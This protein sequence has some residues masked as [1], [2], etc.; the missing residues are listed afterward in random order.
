MD[1][2]GQLDA[3][4]AEARAALTAKQQARERALALSRETIRYSANAIRAI[5]RHDVE[6]ARALVETAGEKAAGARAAL[7]EH[8]DILY[9]GFV[10]DA[11]KEF[12]EARITIALVGGEPLPTPAALDVEYPAYFNGLAEVV[13]EI[14][15]YLLDSLRHGD[16]DRCE[17]FLA[18]M[19][20]IY[21]VLVTIDFPDAMTGGLRRSTDL[22][23]GILERTRADF[24]LAARQYD[25]ERKL[26]AFQASAQ[27]QAGADTSA[28]PG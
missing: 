24:T 17:R 14:R 21:T 6:A 3:V 16:I 11:L 13:G 1:F 22:A 15:R 23:R 18:S 4:A 2:A 12:A 27:M 8:P 25:L 10:H 9:A 19:D 26:E 20:D 7:V 28:Y 5:H